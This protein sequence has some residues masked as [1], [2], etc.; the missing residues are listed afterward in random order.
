MCS[1]IAAGPQHDGPTRLQDAGSTWPEPRHVKP[2]RSVGRGD[3]VDAGILDAWREVLSEIFGRCDFIA[4][5]FRSGR[6]TTQG[7]SGSDHS[8]GWVKANGVSEVRSEAVSSVTGTAA[9]VEKGVELA[10]GGGVLVNNG[11]IHIMVVVATDLGI[12][13]ALF[14]VV[15]AECPFLYVVG[16]RGPWLGH[17]EQAFL[18][19]QANSEWD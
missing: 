4:D 6:E 3:K 1:D 18:A 2:V 11:L 5:G 9:D 14:F 19:R 16:E 13:F 12:G 8:F 15:G 10:T 17:G 7:A